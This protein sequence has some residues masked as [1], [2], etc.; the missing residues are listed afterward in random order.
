MTFLK[1]K[2]NQK[3]LINVLSRNNGKNYNIQIDNSKE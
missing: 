2:K 3:N 1:I